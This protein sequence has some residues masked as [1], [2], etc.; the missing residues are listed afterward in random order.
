[1]CAFANAGMSNIKPRSA[2][3]FNVAKTCVLLMFPPSRLLK[4]GVQSF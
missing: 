3:F 1:M 4:N 2:V